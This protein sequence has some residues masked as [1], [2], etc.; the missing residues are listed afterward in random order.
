MGTTTI[1]TWTDHTWNPWVGC[2]RV[3][4]G[5]AHCYIERFLA[6]P[7]VVKR[8]SARHWNLP[9]LWNLEARQ[10]GVKEF[11]FSCSSADFFHPTADPWRP[12]AWR[13]IRSCDSLVFLL[14]TKRPERILDHLP[15]DWGDGYGNVWLGCSVEDRQQLARV[16]I[17]RTIPCALRFL[18][19]EP[20]LEDLGTVNLDGIGWVIVGG[21]SEPDPAK[22]PRPMDLAWAWSL[23]EQA[24]AAGIP[25][26]FKQISGRRQGL[27]ADIFGEVVQEYPDPGAAPP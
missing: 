26:F 17:L 18:S 15:G 14:L 7:W 2:T 5:C 25:R 20:L 27:G 19:C 10:R 4:R 12:A 24:R 23:L 16:D 1:I 3:S 11:V 6:G 13:I 9:G 22:A 21:E 8:S